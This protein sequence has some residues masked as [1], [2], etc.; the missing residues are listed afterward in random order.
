MEPEIEEVV[1]VK[2]EHEPEIVEMS[3]G[4]SSMGGVNL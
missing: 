2:E 1:E 4:L 3:A